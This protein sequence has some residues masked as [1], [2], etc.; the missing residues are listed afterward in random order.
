[1][2]HLPK[3]Y[4]DESEE[5]VNTGNNSSGVANCKSSKRPRRQPVTRHKDFLWETNSNLVN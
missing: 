1:M 5:E 2:N 4:N 3:K